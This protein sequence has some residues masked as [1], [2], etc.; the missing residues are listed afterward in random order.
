MFPVGF[1]S[2]LVL[3]TGWKQSAFDYVFLEQQQR[4]QFLFE[5]RQQKQQLQNI[6]GHSVTFRTDDLH[7]NYTRRTYKVFNLFKVYLIFGLISARDSP[8]SPANTYANRYRERRY[9]GPG[10]DNRLP[11]FTKLSPPSGNHRA[12]ERCD[13]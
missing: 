8:L 3:E 7:G 10:R 12:S 11:R 2:V 9:L 5:Q 6:G 13:L 1:G 4:Y